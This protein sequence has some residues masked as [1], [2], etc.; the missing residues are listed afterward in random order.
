MKKRAQFS[1]FCIVLLLTGILG[2]TFA[3][4]AGT[5]AGGA[6]PSPTVEDTTNA[7]NT[8]SIKKELIFINDAGSQVREPNV[9]YTY[10]IAAVTLATTDNV[11]VRDV[12]GISGKVKSGVAAAL[13]AETS[14]TIVFK[15]DNPLVATSANG[16]A[17]TRYVDYA[18][19]ASQFP[20]PGI[21]RYVITESNTDKAAVGVEEVTTYVKTRY[22]D[23]YV[24]KTSETDT[25]PVIYGYVLFEDTTTTAFDA[26]ADPTVN[27]DKKSEGFVNTSDTSAGEY[28]DVDVYRT[29]DLTITKETK[30]L[31]A[32][33]AND[34][35]V[36]ITFAMPATI[37]A[38]VLVN[39][40]LGGN[41][42]LDGTATDSVGTYVTLDATSFDGTV[43]DGSSISFIGVPEGTTFSIV[44]TNNTPDS[45]KVKISLATDGDLLAEA[46]IPAGSTSAS[47]TATA[48][49]TTS[50][51]TITNTLDMI[52][53]TGFVTRFAPYALLLVGG[54][55]LIVLGRTAVRR[56]SK[57][58]EA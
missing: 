3:F 38:D 37:T 48:I 32:D 53:P 23:V 26:F 9:T 4:A 24:R 31:M 13:P 28:S 47:S 58:Q 7:I 29:Q 43:D 56:S 39:T 15:E 41:A 51:V 54:I 21:Y 33:K 5:T 2:S 17:A 34:F 1:L 40:D 22:L 16:I 52:S 10:T 25:T 50:D 8:V 57:K 27:L 20:G 44:E 11:N 12:D 42:T 19:D 45:Y 30:G 18:F 6:V 35:P 55:L 14:A 46:I 49:D 36:T